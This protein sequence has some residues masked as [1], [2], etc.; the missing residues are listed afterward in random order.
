ME[1]ETPLDDF[2][3]IRQ[4][5]AE[6]AMAEFRA[7]RP[8]A[9][10]AQD[11]LGLAFSVEGLTDRQLGFVQGAGRDP[12]LIVPSAKLKQGTSPEGAAAAV[13]LEPLTR[14]TIEAYAGHTPAGAVN[15]A[16]SQKAQISEAGEVET[17]AL[18]LAYLSLLLPAVMVTQASEGDLL[19]LPVL[20]AG[21]GDLLAFR[22][23][24]ARALHI[25]ARTFVPL[26]ETG[27]CEFVVFRGGDGFRDHIAVIVGNPAPNGPVLARIHSA[28]LTGDLF[29]SLKC[30]CGDQLRGTVRA[31]SEQGGGVL[32]YLDQ[33]GR[34]N[35]IANKLR[36]YALQEQ[37]FDTYDADAMLGFGLDQRRFDF[38][39]GMLKQLGFTSVR[40]M[41]N[42]PQKVAALRES[43]LDVVSTHRVLTR[44]T[45]HNAKYLAAKRDKAGHLIG[46]PALDGVDLDEVMLPAA[47]Q[48]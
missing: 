41:T 27:R 7:A 47:T 43:G 13:R 44:T 39:A 36:A 30:D 28:C 40:L 19:R 37:G 17:A 2:G 10:R 6:R 25:V 1:S 38:A 33:E 5:A 9:I 29:A 16:A 42:N 48:P 21:A 46:D 24:E 32:L 22:D 11:S 15:G 4:I 31:M 20:A 23:R 34:G 8:V 26:D 45:A 12:R 14:E 35:G 18:A 3:D